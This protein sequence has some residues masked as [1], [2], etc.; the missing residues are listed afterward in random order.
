[1][2]VLLRRGPGR[3]LA[4]PGRVAGL[5]AAALLAAASASAGPFSLK[6]VFTLGAVYDSNVFF[7]DEDPQDDYFGSVVIDLPLEYKASPRSSLSARYLIGG[8]WY[9]T[10]KQLDNFPTRQDA[11]LRYSYAPT[12]GWSF[13]LNGN[14][15][16]SQRTQDVFPTSGVD[17]GRR[18][19]E[20]ASGGASLGRTLG[21]SGKLDLAY[22]YSRAL[23]FED[24]TTGYHTGS[25]TLGKQFG[26]RTKLDLRYVYDLYRF[27]DDTSGTT[28]VGTF[29]LTHSFS[30]RTTLSLRGGM[31][32]GGDD[33]SPEADVSLNH[34]W[35]RGS[36]S[37][38]YGHT[39]SF[40]P[41]RGGQS[42]LSEVDRAGLG[43]NF[44]D[45]RYTVSFSG[46][47]YRNRTD[48]FKTDT[49]RGSV[50]AVYLLKYWFGL[51]AAYEYSYQRL[52]SEPRADSERHMAQVGFVI[53]P[54]RKKEVQ[55]PR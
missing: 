37:L 33:T 30:S 11:S 47:Y 27:E 51:G 12:R 53:S 32:F 22:T 50:N 10:L 34:A 44:Q 24:E 14:Y 43:L 26:K 21:A 39:L 52:L 16:E 29:G 3:F 17:L 5:V 48:T 46:N 2:S 25:A 38:F 7:T 23:Y 55:P 9:R 28:H 1:M 6:P 54:W 35:R 31:R 15:A 8:E 42:S 49:Y 41:V 20:T 13:G 19:T 45:R 40:V 18:K 36:F 4:V